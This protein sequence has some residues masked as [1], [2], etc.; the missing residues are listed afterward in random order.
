MSTSLGALRLRCKILLAPAFLVLVLIGLSAYTLQTL[1]LNQAV[2]DRLMSG[3]V[4]Q[5]EI[6]ADFTATILV[7][8]VRLYSLTAT[9]A[10]ETDQKKIAAMAGRSTAA[11]AQI[12]EKLKTLESIETN[13]TTTTNMIG[14]L[15]TA[16]ASYLKQA[17]NAVE[18][19]E[20]DAASALLF[21]VNAE[22]SFLQI[23]K[24]ADELATAS[25]KSR[26]R[27][28]SA[29]NDRLDRQ[30]MVFPAIVLISLV[31]G[32]LVSIL[33]SGGIARPVVKIATVI[34]RIAEGKLDQV[35]P[36]TD[37]RDEIG[38]IA[39][40]VNVFK[41]K[42]L[43]SE[44]MRAERG[45]AESREAVRRKDEMGKL[46]NE[47]QTTIGNIVGVVSGASGELEAAARTLTKTAETTQV[48]SSMVTSASEEASA[49]VRSVAS[50]TEE[51]TGVV[52][53]IARRVQESSHI[54]GEAVI[55]A[56]KTDARITALS[57]A[58]SRIGDVVK[59]I[60]AIAEQTNLL[61][62]NATI[63]AARAGE[64]GRGFA[65]VAQEVKAL[66]AQTAKA[67]NDIGTQ[68]AS[69][70]AATRESVDA[71]KEISGTIGHIA[72]IATAI[73]A[74]V[75]EQGAATQ[76]ISRNV[77]QAALGTTQ[78]ATNITDVNR[79]AS[80]TGAASSQV[81]GSAQSLARES[82]RLKDEVEK[83]VFIVRAA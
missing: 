78:V 21:V 79:G 2:T 25:N 55:Q 74:A 77:Q 5:A 27:E 4:R 42:L 76:E 57:V 13:Q 45:E 28:I 3:P 83:F 9:A 10:N 12:P 39:R 47:F 58:A 80:D 20:G 11:L 26:E 40:A 81:F 31:I 24:L 66:S 62:L 56:E 73:A 70:Q 18:M 51:L 72:E 64:A 59:L 30:V 82:S 41:N 32:C 65:V 61:A 54:A 35:V 68:I 33:V 48:L 60:T 46:A 44:R 17:K 49:N 1:R 67:T 75:E 50:A 38:S 71:I 34:E 36:A 23:E 15:K 6:I 63:E 29:A 7:A 19:A 53:E 43:E 8:H 37:Q 22:R 69:M 16:V 52:S 14:M